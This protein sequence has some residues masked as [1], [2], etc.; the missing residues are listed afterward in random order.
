MLERFI[1]ECTQRKDILKESAM[2]PEDSRWEKLI[3]LSKLKWHETNDFYV[4][5]TGDMEEESKYY[6]RR[7]QRLED[8]KR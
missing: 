6:F 4:Q 2:N 8:A 3:K 7:Q 5:E 1:I